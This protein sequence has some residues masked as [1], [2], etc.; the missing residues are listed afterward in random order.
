MARLGSGQVTARRARPQQI[1][2]T[3]RAGRSWVFKA[4]ASNTSPVYVGNST[5]SAST[6]HVLEP[7]DTFQIDRSYQA[8]ALFEH[9]PQDIY[10]VGSGG[11]L[12]WISFDN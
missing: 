8:T 1:S 9:T 5:V 3:G 4:S 11:V 12:T 10:V 2:A 6:G 7:G